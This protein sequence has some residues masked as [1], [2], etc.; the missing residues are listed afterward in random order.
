MNRI[1][2]LAVALGACGAMTSCSQTTARRDSAA[3]TEPEPQPGS[4]GLVAERQ[5][6][7]SP[8]PRHDLAI[9]LMDGVIEDLRPGSAAYSRAIEPAE[10]I[11]SEAAD[12]A[13]PAIDPGRKVD[14]VAARKYTRAREAMLTNDLETARGLLSAAQEIDPGS[15]RIEAALADVNARMGDRA[16]SALHATRA[17]EL[18]DTSARVRVLAALGAEG[19]FDTIVRHTARA[20]TQSPVRDP[21]AKALA[22]IILGN[23]LI[24]QGRLSAG[25]EILRDAL[26]MFDERLLSDQT[27]RRELIGVFT[28]RPELWTGV[29]DVL[30]ELRLPDQALS[31]YSTARSLV[32]RTPPGLVQRRA[33][34]HASAGRTA[35]S[36]ISLL[37]ALDEDPGALGP[38]VRE[39][40]TTLAQRT[41]LRRPIVDELITRA[42]DSS[43]LRSQRARILEI[44][45]LVSEDD[46]RESML[47]DTD[48]AVLSPIG[49]MIALENAPDP[50]RRAEAIINANPSIAPTIGAALT[51]VHADPMRAIASLDPG[52][53]LRLTLAVQLQRA[54]LIDPALAPSDQNA[55]AMNP[56]ILAQWIQALSMN[57]RFD[58]ADRL[59]GSAIEG[60]DTLTPGARADLVV[61]L[62]QAHQTPRA[63]EI[64][65][66][67]DEIPEPTT[68]DLLLV[69]RVSLT[70]GDPEGARSALERALALDPLDE[71]IYEQLI[72]LHTPGGLLESEE[73]LQRVSRELSRAIPSAAL[74]SLIRAGDMARQGLLEP[75]A[76][77]LL[78][79]NEA[80][81]RR[82]IGIDLLISIWRTLDDRAADPDA[83]DKGIEILR[84]RLESDPGAIDIARS[85]ARLLNASD[86]QDEALALLEDLSERFPT[87]AVE[88]A[89]ETMLRADPERMTEADELAL[90]RLENRAGLANAI[91]RMEIASRLDNLDEY[92]IDQLLPAH[93]TITLRPDESRRIVAILSTHLRQ[94]D[95]DDDLV[96]GL[97]RRARSMGVDG[98]AALAQIELVA[99]AGSNGYTPESYESALRA[100]LESQPAGT[101][102]EPQP[103]L[104]VI[105][106]QGLQR[107]GHTDDATPL[108][109]RAC[110]VNGELVP[111]RVVNLATIIGRS[112]T[113][114]DAI[115]AAEILTRAGVIAQAADAAEEGLGTSARPESETSEAQNKADL[116]YSA[117]VVAMFFE[118]ESE[119]M[120]MYRGVLALDPDHVW[121]C[122]DL[123]YHLAERLE[124]L[125]EAERLLER[126]HE[127]LPDNASVIDSLG[128]VRYA[129]GILRDETDDQ[130]NVV[131][132]GAIPLLERSL[133]LDK[134]NEN[135]TVHDHL[136]DARWMAR[137]FDG[138][139][140]A[141]R[142]AEAQ[143]G[144]RL[145]ELMDTETD[146]SDAQKRLAEQ[147]GKIRAKLSDAALGQ[148]PDVAP[149]AAGLDVPIDDRA[150]D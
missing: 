129:R 52:S 13:P 42:E 10:R 36:A 143:I 141:W 85:L 20:W 119:A 21:G 28:R 90:S 80:Q 78:A 33:A 8:A 25:A 145:T 71:S 18:G 131:R 4:L 72:N 142:A 95:Q 14:P 115:Q 64:A 26:G 43:I 109:A 101:E 5:A 77:T 11:L 15:A 88:R 41:D 56:T 68:T 99:L 62:L 74:V 84:D 92:P 128:W 149:N 32:S 38:E 113:V 39:W 47:K 89:H 61:A 87:R 19:D 9:A 51:R 70:Q 102:T 6:I 150:S 137:D 126:A 120:D 124:S 93:P 34:A 146:T 96:L 46:D 60:I 49:A 44:A 111:R 57:E 40:F 135:P 22:G 37:D 108:L 140:E 66:R 58:A 125:D 27:W 67:I 147:L 132:E 91:E 12:D 133:A 107:A 122:N 116:V 112:G 86:R 76:N 69:A 1:L 17:I 63:V 134:G 136:G 121:A 45:L 82:G 79:A 35:M 3:R 105:A 54:D 59:I 50:V 138:A 53:P 104:V 94:T 98:D 30:L 103:D 24:E 123:G 130:G 148:P 31:A 117:A 127:G 7:R 106:V 75:A 139:I 97:A 118:R 48:P 81:P 110:V 55:S 114:D 23:T 65:D 83:M 29:G 100:M 144:A 2:A 73:E 16:Q